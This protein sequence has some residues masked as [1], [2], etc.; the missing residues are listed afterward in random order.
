MI[1]NAN[2]A[3]V[4]ALR[5]PSGWPFRTAI[6]RG[7]AG[8]GKTLLGRWFAAAGLGETIDGLGGTTGTLGEGI[9]QAIADLENQDV[10]AAIDTVLTTVIE[11]L[12]GDES[13]VT[14][15][16]EGTEILVN[17][18]EEGMQGLM[19]GLEDGT[20]LAGAG[21][22]LGSLI[23]GLLVGDGVSDGGALGETCLLYTSPSPRD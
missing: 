3:V 16:G 12:A 15:L 10:A 4:E 17:S 9:D 14:G 5:D 11:A 13:V 6:L 7:A 23:E 1:G 2:Q 8:S 22:L 19:D 21:D 18:L 20:P